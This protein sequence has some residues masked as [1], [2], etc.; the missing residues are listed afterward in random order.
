MKLSEDALV[1]PNF[2]PRMSISRK[3]IQVRRPPKQKRSKWLRAAFQTFTTSFA[4]LIINLGLFFRPNGT[5]GGNPQ[6]PNP[7][8]HHS[9]APSLPTVCERCAGCEGICSRAI[10]GIGIG[11]AEL[12]G[13]GLPIDW[14][15]KGE[16][17]SFL[18]AKGTRSR[19]C[20]F[21]CTIH[22]EGEERIQG[23]DAGDICRGIFLAKD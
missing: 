5:T 8:K 6:N 18:A 7:Y 17:V 23:R 22:G 4:R 19:K 15:A 21:G 2:L 16:L 14:I 11:K 9:A 3:V 13:Y 20:G 10:A 1:S 12:M